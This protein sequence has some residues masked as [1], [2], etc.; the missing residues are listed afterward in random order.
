M[1]SIQFMLKMCWCNRCQY[2]YGWTIFIFKTHG[3]SFRIVSKTTQFTSEN[4][5]VS[6]FLIQFVWN[7]HS[8]F[9]SCCNGTKLM[10]NKNQMGWNARKKANRFAFRRSFFGFCFL[11]LSQL[12]VKCA[13]R[14]SFKG[15]TMYREMKS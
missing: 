7:K 15:K 4:V 3:I 10:H 12:N 5:F 9:F 8:L 13:L 1:C 14:Y 6:C 11:G 2:M